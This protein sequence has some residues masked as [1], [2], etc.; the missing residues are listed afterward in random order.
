MVTDGQGVRPESLELHILPAD[1]P[2][3]HRQGR[4]AARRL[5][6]VIGHGQFRPQALGEESLALGPVTLP[7][8]EDRLRGQRRP[9]GLG[10]QGG[11]ECVEDFRRLLDKGASPLGRGHDRQAGGI[12][13]IDGAVPVTVGAGWGGPSRTW[14]KQW[15]VGGSG[16]Q[17]PFGRGRF[18]LDAGGCE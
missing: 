1:G 10:A 4:A 6:H 15:Q 11:L 14:N 13:Q 17:R 7:A 8:Q 9:V 12:A 5:Q 18:G 2:G 3:L 16:G